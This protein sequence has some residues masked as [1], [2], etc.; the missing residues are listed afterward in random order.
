MLVVQ[1]AGAAKG[2]VAADG[3]EAVD[4]EGAEDFGAAGAAFRRVE[5]LAAQGAEDDAAALDDVAD[6]VAVQDD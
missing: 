3:N 5:V 1:R 6:V 4:V 2:A